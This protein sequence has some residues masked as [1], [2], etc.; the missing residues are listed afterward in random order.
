[1]IFAREATTAICLLQTLHDKD[2]MKCLTL[3]E[4]LGKQDT[5]SKL[6]RKLSF[7]PF[8]LYHGSNN[9]SYMN[10]IMVMHYNAAYGCGK[11]LKVVLLMGQMLKSH[12]KSCAGFP[13]DDTTSSSNWKPTQPTAHKSPHCTSKC[14]KDAKPDGTKESTSHTKESTSHGQ[15]KKFHKK[16]KD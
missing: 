7:C 5:D 9:L 14:T 1:M 10:H 15:C 3:E 12:L 6:V 11:C 16:S 4:K 2:S 8:C 13:K